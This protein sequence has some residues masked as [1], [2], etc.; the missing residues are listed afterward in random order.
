MT[1]SWSRRRILA[2]ALTV[3]AA[4]ALRTHAARADEP[5]LLRCWLETP[6]SHTRNVV[7]KDYLGRLEA[8]AGGRIKT[9]LF[10][11]GEL[12]PVA[13]LSRILPDMVAAV[14]AEVAAG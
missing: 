6:P 9:Q 7:M 4:P 2:S 3:V 8:A 12:F 1:R 14:T 11:S 13:T 5:L 10:E